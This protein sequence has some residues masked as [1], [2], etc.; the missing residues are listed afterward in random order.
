VSETVYEMHI[1]LVVGLDIFHYDYPV[2][3]LFGWLV[4][5]LFAL[6]RHMGIPIAS[7][8]SVDLKSRKKERI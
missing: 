3:C 4:G 7:Y 5:C 1:R 6:S 2:V 8:E